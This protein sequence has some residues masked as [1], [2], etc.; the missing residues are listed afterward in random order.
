MSTISW[1]RRRKGK[2]KTYIG[3]EVDDLDAGP[4]R[5]GVAGHASR[6]DASACRARR[7]RRANERGGADVADGSAAKENQSEGDKS[8]P[9][10]TPHPSDPARDLPVVHVRPDA[11][12]RR[13]QPVKVPQGVALCTTHAVHTHRL[14]QQSS[15]APR[16]RADVIYH[17]T[18]ERVG[19]EVA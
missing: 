6:G 10:T 11:L 15:Q 1:F 12:A 18:V 3:E 17:P 5:Q 16:R 19:L 4:R 13:R 7:H 8:A 9:E 2:I 14:P